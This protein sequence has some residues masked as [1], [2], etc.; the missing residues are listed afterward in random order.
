MFFMLEAVNGS[1]CFIGA[2]ARR[3]SMVFKTEPFY[4]EA[5]AVNIF[6]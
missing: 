3:L 6:R 1:A 5:D 2:I 4:S